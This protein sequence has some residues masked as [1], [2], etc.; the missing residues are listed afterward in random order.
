MHGLRPLALD[1][2]SDGGDT[3]GERERVIRR[4]ECIVEEK[5]M[6]TLTCESEMTSND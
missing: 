4:S 1:C 2:F 6:T 3:P 5:K